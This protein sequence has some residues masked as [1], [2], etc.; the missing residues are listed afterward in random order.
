MVGMLFH[1][2]ESYFRGRAL[3]VRIHK[4]KELLATW[5]GE[6]NLE[7]LGRYA[8][9]RKGFLS[10]DG[11]TEG[12]K[13]ERVPCRDDDGNV[14]MG[15]NR[16]GVPVPYTEPVGRRRRYNLYGRR[17][18]VMIQEKSGYATFLIVRREAVGRETQVGDRMPVILPGE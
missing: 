17:I 4:G 18:A 8:S 16:A 2:D 14:K 6:V 10:C 3:P 15:K 5:Q 1:E 12:H 13:P 11:F 9:W 7:D